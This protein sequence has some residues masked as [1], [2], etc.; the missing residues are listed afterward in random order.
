[1]R[2]KLCLFRVQATHCSVCSLFEVFEQIEL[3][4]LF[5][6]NELFGQDEVFGLFAV[7]AVRQILKA[8]TYGAGVYIIL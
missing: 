3:V 5:G 1:M 4:G 6:Q 2:H 7:R 8:N